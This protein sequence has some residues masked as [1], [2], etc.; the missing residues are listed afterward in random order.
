MKME[1]LIRSRAQQAGLAGWRGELAASG[2]FAAGCWTGPGVGGLSLRL[3]VKIKRE[4]GGK[5][6]LRCSKGQ[7]MP[8]TQC[9]YRRAL[10]A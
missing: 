8:Q 6:V 1:E 10:S 7:E 2:V 5:N 4:K 9:R 3:F